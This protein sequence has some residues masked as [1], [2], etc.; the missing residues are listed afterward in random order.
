MKPIIGITSAWSA[1]TILCETPC[2][3]SVKYYNYT[4]EGCSDAI[5]QAGGIPFLIPAVK[6][7][8]ASL[9][10]CAEEVLK[11]VDA[12]YFSGGAGGGSCK[13]R[14]EYKDLYAQQPVRSAWEDVLLKKAYEVDL[15]VFGTCRGHQMITVALGGELD[16]VTYMSH[17]QTEPGHEGSHTVNIVKN[18]LLERIVGSEPWLV[19]SFHTQKVEVPAPGFI[20]CAQMDDGSVEAV[21]ST[22]KT[23]F[24]GTQFHPEMMIYDERA[25]VLLKAF[26][27]AATEYSQKK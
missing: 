26:V 6:E 7:S 4:E 24:L 2:G 22:E 21:E 1:E 23:F 20:V 18:S 12:L 13:L 5:Y 15:P 25:K 16:K 19:N 17:R 9:E 14:G 27:K 11:K 8:V 3:T 10:E